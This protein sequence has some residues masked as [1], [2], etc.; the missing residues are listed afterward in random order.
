[1]AQSTLHSSA[2]VDARRRASFDWTH[3]TSR[4]PSTSRASGTQ[5]GSTSLQPQQESPG[6]VEHISDA[7]EAQQWKSPG[8]LP[9]H[10]FNSCAR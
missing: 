1:M 2:A 5:P 9:Q 6:E 3:A 4:F 8:D 7:D 10:S